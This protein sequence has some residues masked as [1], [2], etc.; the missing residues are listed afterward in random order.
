[1]IFDVFKRTKT[2]I[3][4]NS[5]NKYYVE[6]LQK[7]K[8]AIIDF[9]RIYEKTAKQPIQKNVKNI[10]KTTENILKEVIENKQKLR[11]LTMF[12]EYYLF[13]TIN[14][15]EQYVKIKENRLNSDD[16]EKLVKEIEKFIPQAEIAFTKILEYLT[17]PANNKTEIDIAV[18]IE[19]LKSK[20][21][22]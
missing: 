11:K 20:K 15:L 3:D 2:K 1:M 22:L 6:L 18:M 8:S 17:I 5:D 12:V 4:D 9:K 7:I 16:S 14:I 19:E 10:C 13:E 21:L